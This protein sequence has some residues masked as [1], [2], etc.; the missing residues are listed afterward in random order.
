[1]PQV[2]APPGKDMAFSLPNAHAVVANIPTP[3]TDVM[4]RVNRIKENVFII[5]PM[6]VTLSHL[7]SPLRANCNVC[8]RDNGGNGPRS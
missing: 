5:K 2:N 6:A 7:S 8:L 1:M 3:M 4:A